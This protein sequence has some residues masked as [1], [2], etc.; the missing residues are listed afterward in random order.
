VDVPPRHR[1]AAGRQE[2]VRQDEEKRQEERQEEEEI[3]TG[4]ETGR[5]T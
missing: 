5:E 3:Q 2:E 4:G 1:V